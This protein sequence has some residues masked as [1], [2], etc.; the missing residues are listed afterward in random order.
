MQPLIDSLVQTLEDHAAKIL[1]G[2]VLM[3]VGWLFGRRRA[4]AN[5]QKQEF[6]DRLNVSLNVIDQGVLKIRTLSEKSC[7]D[8]F[9]NSVAAEKSQRLARQTT[10]ADPLLPLSR[11]DTW[12]FLNAVLND[13]S[14]Q[15][16]L[17]HIRKD[18]G[19]PVQTEVYLVCLTCEQFGELRT[20]KI[21][22]MVI[23]RGLL[24]NLPKDAPKF[25]ASHH[26]TRWATLQFMAAEYARNPWRFLEVE[27]SA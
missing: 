18:V 9:L 23:R 19:A 6:L 16:A 27:L 4:H 11:E 20:R 7:S 26:S 10:A 24:T 13:L 22:A 14:E 1:F 5:W 2:F 8:V 25:T 17:G 15:F 3:W 12:Y 21:R